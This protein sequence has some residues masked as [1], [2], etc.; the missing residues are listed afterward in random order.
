LDEIVKT[1]WVELAKAQQ[2][3]PL[4]ELIAATRDLPPPR[5]F[6]G[7]LAA[8]PSRGVHLIAEIK[9]QSPSAGQLRP[10]FDP[11]ALAKVYHAHGADA[12]SVLTDASYFAGR[13]AFI[14]SVKAAVPLPVLRKDF[15]V[16]PY[17][18]YESRLAGADAVLLIGEVLEPPMLGEML[19]VAFAL[20]MTS[21]VEVHEAG[22]LE[23][24]RTAVPFPND[25]RSLLGINNRDLKVQQVDLATTEQLA[26][27]AGAG[28]IIVS[29]SGIKTRADVQRLI[30]AGA[31]ALLIGETFMRADD[32]G[33]KITELLGPVSP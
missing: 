7:A 26:G 20:G 10:D 4:A 6:H 18:I 8:Q 30:R 11:V 17:Q 14:A 22:T 9:K 5:D 25:K 16:D 3:H 19:D 29:E 32:I 12:L 24:V 1:K 2:Q 27:L 33:A 15:M 21:L 31:R 28:T 13:L 23:R